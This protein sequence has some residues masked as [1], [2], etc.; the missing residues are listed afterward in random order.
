MPKFLLVREGFDDL[1][2]FVE[3]EAESMEQAIQKV[4]GVDEYGCEYLT[5]LENDDEML[6]SYAKLYQVVQEA[7]IDLE[8][9]AQTREEAETEQD[10]KGLLDA[11][12]ALLAR[13]KKELG[14]E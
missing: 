2:D 11:K 1:E 3:L 7:E 5:V 9:L 4:Q 8:I 6:H 13:L 14:E 10:R 12:K